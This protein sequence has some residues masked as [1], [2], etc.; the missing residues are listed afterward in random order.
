LKLNQFKVTKLFI[1][2][3]ESG[4]NEYR[5]VIILWSISFKKRAKI[6]T[7]QGYYKN[8]RYHLKI[9][10][11]VYYHH[12]YHYSRNVWYEKEVMKES[13]REKEKERK[14][15]SKERKLIVD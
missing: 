3:G 4:M 8:M 12:Y 6:P 14:E 7:I 13:E 11:W 15:G 10:M 2:I 5:K 1:N 9:I